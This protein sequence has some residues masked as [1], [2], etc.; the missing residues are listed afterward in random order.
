M[1]T[2]NSSKK[3]VV[4]RLPGLSDGRP[5]S[6]NSIFCGL[7]EDEFNAITI[8]IE[9]IYALAKMAFPHEAGPTHT[10][11]LLIQERAGNIGTILDVAQDRYDVAQG[12]ER[13]VAHG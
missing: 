8:E 13:Q 5:I 10:A 4:S 11:L 6:V 7:I 2:K 12:E 9:H 3:N 1:A